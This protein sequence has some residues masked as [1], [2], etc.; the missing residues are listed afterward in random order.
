MWIVARTE[1]SPEG[2][3]DSYMICR[4]KGEALEAYEKLLG[5]SIC[6]CMAPIVEATEPHWVDGD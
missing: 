2:G 5:V 3:V 1:D 4:N 6:A